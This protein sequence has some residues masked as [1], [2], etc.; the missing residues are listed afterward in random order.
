MSV[1]LFVLPI[2][3]KVKHPEDKYVWIMRWVGMNRVTGEIKAKYE[4]LKDL[5]VIGI[6]YRIGDSVVATGN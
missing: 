1:I 5:P 2:L 6:V 4:P 3:L